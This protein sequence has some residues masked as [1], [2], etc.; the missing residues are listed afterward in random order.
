MTDTLR[1][2]QD[3]VI[4]VGICGCA[5]TQGLA[6]MENKRNVDAD[7]LLTRDKPGEWL[8]IV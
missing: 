8:Q 3:G 6:S 4:E 5:I 1:A 7:L 2:Q